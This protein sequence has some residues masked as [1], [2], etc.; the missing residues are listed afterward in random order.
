M[1]SS[2]TPRFWEAYSKLPKSIQIRARKQ[3]R[4]WEANPSHPSL[5]FKPVGPF[6]S[7]RIALGYRAL[8]LKRADRIYWFWIG[9]HADYD[10][11]LKESQ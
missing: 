7:V 11:L 6:W 5:H 8:G 9:S 10:E 1:K 2:T 3:Y 4:L